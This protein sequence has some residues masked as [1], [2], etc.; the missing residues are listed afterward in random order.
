MSQNPQQQQQPAAAQGPPTTPQIRPI[1]AEAQPVAAQSALGALVT[2]KG[3]TLD[4]D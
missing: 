4:L 1:P 2:V 3:Y